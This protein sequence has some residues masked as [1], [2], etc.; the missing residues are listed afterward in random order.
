M[1]SHPFLLTQYLRRV[2]RMILDLSYIPAFHHWTQVPFTTIG[3]GSRRGLVR[4][5]GTKVKA[6]ETEAIQWLVDT[7]FEHFKRLGIKEEDIPQ[8]SPAR[9]LGLTLVDME[10]SLYVV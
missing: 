2:L 8:L 9:P 3:P 10:H 7:Q 4:I 6:V 1:P 5:F